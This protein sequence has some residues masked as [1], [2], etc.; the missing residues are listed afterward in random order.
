MPP[1]I[2]LNPWSSENQLEEA[3]GSA[4]SLVTITDESTGNLVTGAF[5]GT[6]TTTS[7]ASTTA[8]GTGG[9]GEYEAESESEE[10]TL[11]V[12]IGNAITGAL[13]SISPP[14]P[15]F[16]LPNPAATAIRPMPNS[17]AG[18]GRPVNQVVIW[19]AADGRK[20]LAI[21]EHEPITKIAFSEDGRLLAY[22]SEE[23]TVVVEPQG[24]VSP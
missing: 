1:F 22:G 2:P 16:P 23:C 19:S 18:V 13:F 20:V 11:V 15:P 17:A 12:R 6:Q 8:V 7:A 4:V 14:H 24:K 10:T 5:T 9:R 3:A 21:D